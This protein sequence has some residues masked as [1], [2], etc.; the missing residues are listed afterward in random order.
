MKE[1]DFF[2]KFNKENNDLKKYA[3]EFFAGE[4]FDE[5]T[6]IK[7]DVFDF[8][9]NGYK[10]HDKVFSIFNGWCTVTNIIKDSRFPLEI[11]IDSTA[12]VYK[13]PFKICCTSDGKYFNEDKIPILYPNEIKLFQD[14]FD[15]IENNYTVNDKVFSII[16]G[17]GKIISIDHGSTYP[18]NIKINN[19][20]ADYTSDGKRYEDDL[21]PIIVPKDIYTKIKGE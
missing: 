16:E 21:F 9:K 18:L 8:I 13:E 19:A 1:I 10:I 15:F 20:S 14:R 7:K 3:N 11:S 4:S 5:F 17:W 6:Y 2:K 12:S